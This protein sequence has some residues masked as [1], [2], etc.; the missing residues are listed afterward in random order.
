MPG[1]VGDIAGIRLVVR[2]RGEER[3]GRG[4][5][6]LLLVV[7]VVVVLLGVVRLVVVVL[8][9]LALGVMCHLGHG[10]HLRASLRGPSRTGLR[11]P[12]ST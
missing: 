5:R 3:A 10:S 4:R 2:E 9:L 6:G 8:L 7:V 11:E 1:T 12:W